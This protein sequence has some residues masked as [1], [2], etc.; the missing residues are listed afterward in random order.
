MHDFLLL[1]HLLAATVWTGGHIILSTIILPEVLRE[2]S[3]QK[4]IQFESKYEKVGMPAFI[5]QVVTGLILAYQLLPDLKAWVLSTH[6]VARVILLK[7]TLLA[8]TIGFALDAKFRVLP[9]LSEKNLTDMAWHIVPVTLL[10][11]L[12]VVV[13][14]SFRTGWFY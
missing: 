6:P 13:G 8:L 10:S 9:K 1:I 5:I 12:F 3:P 14:V 7:L 2:R 4:L 11:V